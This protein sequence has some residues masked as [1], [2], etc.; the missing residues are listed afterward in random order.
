MGTVSTAATLADRIEWLI[1][2][3]WPDDVPASG[4]NVEIA[5]AIAARTGEEISS[6][7]VWKLRTGRQDNP[8][9]KTLTALATFFSVPIGYFGFADE[10]AP[11][12]VGLVD[13]ALLRGLRD[14]VIRSDVLRALIGLSPEARFLLDDVILA[15]AAADRRRRG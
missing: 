7:T 6:T 9:L 2:N 3:S 1:A 12:D 4:T 13:Q 10:A 5:Q 8:Q 14:G 11:I 15:A